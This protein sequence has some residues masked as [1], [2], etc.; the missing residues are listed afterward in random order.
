PGNHDLIER[1]LDRCPD[2]LAYFPLWSLPQNGPIGTPGAAH[3]PDLRGK[4]ERQRKFLDLAGAAYP[5]MANYSFD[6]GGAHW[7]VLDTNTYVDW[8]D[9]ELRAWLERDLASDVARDAT[10][11]FVA[12][13]HPPFHSSKTHADEQ[14][15][16]VLAEL[17]ERLRVDIVFCG[18]IHN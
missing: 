12:L 7:T 16:R 6:Y 1:D 18:H 15:T 2:G 17:L 14:R 11:R 4:V 8:T 3:T 10:W 9:P 13:H 5:R